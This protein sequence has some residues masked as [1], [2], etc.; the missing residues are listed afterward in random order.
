LTRRS[1]EIQVIPFDGAATYYG[2]VLDSANADKYFEKLFH[3]V[4]WQQD[5]VLIYGKRYVTKRKTA[6]Y[7][8][9]GLS[10]KYSGTSRVALPWT[11]ELQELKSLVEKITDETYNSCLL[12]LYH[13]GTE[14]MSWHRDDEKMLKKDGAIA[15]MSFGEDRKFSFKHRQ[16]KETHSIVLGH[17]SLLVMKGEIQQ[18]W[19]HALPKSTK[20][21]TP[22]INLTFRTIIR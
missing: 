14:G 20:I 12:N 8:D 1:D 15:S 18:H 21:K 10:Y 2:A 16:T 19:M 5:E 3:D 22:R 4:S 6:W 11:L 17:G 9:N 13:D 7:G